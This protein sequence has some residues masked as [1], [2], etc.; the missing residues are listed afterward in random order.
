MVRNSK[1]IKV[2]GVL[3]GFVRKYAISRDGISVST[4]DGVGQQRNVVVLALCAERL[5]PINFVLGLVAEDG[6]AELG[7]R[8]AET[9]LSA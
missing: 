7:Q 6:I 5:L 8:I 4:R 9:E 1:T 3:S 2:A